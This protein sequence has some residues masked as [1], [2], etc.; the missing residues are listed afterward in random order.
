M[1]SNR[2]KTRGMLAGP[3]FAPKLVPME[4]PN[5]KPTVS[6]QRQLGR[7]LV[8][9][10][11]R[12]V[13]LFNAPIT[14]VGNVQRQTRKTLFERARSKSETPV[15]QIP[16]SSTDFNTWYQLRRSR[17]KRAII[18]GKKRIREVVSNE[19]KRIPIA[20]EAEFKLETLD[21]KA[22]AEMAYNIGINSILEV[23]RGVDG[24]PTHI[25]V[26]R[27]SRHSPEAPLWWDHP[28]GLIR[29]G[30][31][32]M[33]VI[34]GRVA[35]EVGVKPNQVQ[36][37]GPGLKPTNQETWLTLHRIDRANNYNAIVVQ[38]ADISAADATHTLR[39]KIKDAQAKGDPW[40][41]VDFKLI[42]RTP[43]AIRAF[44]KS[45]DKVWM[46]EPLRLY[47]R[48]LYKVQKNQKK[49]ESKQKGLSKTKIG[50]N[51]PSLKKTTD[52]P[53]P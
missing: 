27:R 14:R 2:T 49:G 34:S 20:R 10:A 5:P 37:I 17:E 51:S 36:L 26:L 15:I 9:R 40:A 52:N 44:L 31:K 35:L 1:Q 24:Q 50:R 12:G 23:G 8:S 47:A 30:Q 41:P 19:S 46:P 6:G 42:P 13:Q 21:K 18:Q 45:H 53:S 32:P 33:D 39:T 29:A 25:L 7:L 22:H 38:R 3:W 16:V 43:D 11:N 4:M 28:A 48:E